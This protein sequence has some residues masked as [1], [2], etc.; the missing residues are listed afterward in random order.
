[1]QRI[2]GIA[3]HAAPSEHGRLRLVVDC[4][5]SGAR[6][7]TVK[8]SAI[9]SGMVV[10]DVWVARRDA[11]IYLVVRTS[12]PEPALNSACGPVELADV[13][14]GRYTV[15]YGR[16]PVLFGGMSHTNRIAEIEVA[17]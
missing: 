6:T 17:P 1:M 7:I 5:V 9:N 15:L 8:P 3:I 13:P 14:A 10:Y 4:D 12:L 16:P 11:S 2:G